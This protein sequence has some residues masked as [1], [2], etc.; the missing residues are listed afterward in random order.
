MLR[1]VSFYCNR[2][3]QVFL[4]EIIPSFFLYHLNPDANII[5]HSGCTTC[6]QYI[7]LLSSGTTWCIICNS[8]TFVHTFFYILWRVS[9]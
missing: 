9:H 3:K 8:P 4:Y 2:L 5:V 6:L 1:S 7:T